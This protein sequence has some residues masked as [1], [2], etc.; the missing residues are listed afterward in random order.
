[1]NIV[2]PLLGD[3]YP[4]MQHHIVGGQNSCGNFRTCML[5]VL[6]MCVYRASY[7]QLGKVFEKIDSAKLVLQVLP[8]ELSCC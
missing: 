6:L 2:I 7:I 4:A 3:S 8:L 1:M 5:P